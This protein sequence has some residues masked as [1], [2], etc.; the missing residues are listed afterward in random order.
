MTDREV[1]IYIK[2]LCYQFNEGAI[3][4]EEFESFPKRVKDK[5]IR[6]DNGWINKRLEYEKERKEK[7]KAN[8]MR[9]LETKS[10]EER[11]KE[12]GVIK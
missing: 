6:V 11:L 9:N 8:R 5:F 4:D 2:A 12:A 10:L 7:Y 1:G 3:E